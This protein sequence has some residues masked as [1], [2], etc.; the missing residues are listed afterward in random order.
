MTHLQLLGV[1]LAVMKFVLTYVFCG[2]LEIMNLTV[3][4]HVLDSNEKNAF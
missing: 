2:M 1:M 3:H 4:L